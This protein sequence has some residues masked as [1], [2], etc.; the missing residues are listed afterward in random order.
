M[1]KQKYCAKNFKLD[2]AV[3]HGGKFDYS[4]SECTT[5]HDYVTITCPVHGD[6]T[7]KAVKHLVSMHGCAGCA[8][9]IG[10]ELRNSKGKAKFLQKAIDVHGDKYTFDKVVYTKSKNDII[11]TCPV[12]GDFRTTPNRVLRGHGCAHCHYSKNYHWFSDKPTLLYYLRIVD[13]DGCEFYKIGITSRKINE[14]FQPSELK[15]IHVQ[16]TKEYPDGRQAFKVEQSILSKFHKYRLTEP[17]S[18]IR[19]GYSEVFTKDVLNGYLP[20]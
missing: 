11:V 9:D 17:I 19:S 12:H 2:A 6:F 5:L 13:E 18:I 14:R 20:K 8:F 1:R 4:K 16:W 10:A 7:Q 3:V 15:H